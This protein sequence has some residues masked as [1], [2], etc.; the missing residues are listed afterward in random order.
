MNRTPRSV[1]RTASLIAACTA[2]L[3]ACVA[4]SGSAPDGTASVHGVVTDTSGRPIQNAAVY[5]VDTD[6]R[7]STDSLGHY[8]LTG[9]PAGRFQ[10]GT[11][12]IWHIAQRSRLTLEPGASIVLNISL[13]PSPVVSFPDLI[14]EP[15][16]DS[17]P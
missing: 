12:Y 16:V 15:A 9:L 2:C 5:L 4:S 8:E 10:I 3:P 7:T 1:S 6:F 17:S 14:I 13:L 11:M